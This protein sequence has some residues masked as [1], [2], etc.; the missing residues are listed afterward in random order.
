VQS[1]RGVIVWFAKPAP[2]G[3]DRCE[4]AKLES[5]GTCPGLSDT[6]YSAKALAHCSPE[7]VTFSKP[8]MIS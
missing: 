2:D 1:A 8:I 5:F 3:L 4:A 6:E 7:S